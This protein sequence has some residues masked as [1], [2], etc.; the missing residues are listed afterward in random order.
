MAVITKRTE[1][2]RARDKYGAARD[3]YHRALSPASKQLAL[4]A[5]VEAT[6]QLSLLAAG[7]DPETNRDG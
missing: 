1:I 4:V 5:L 6:W 3:R 2:L 7:A